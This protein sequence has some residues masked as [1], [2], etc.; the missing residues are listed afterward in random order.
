M[1]DLGTVKNINLDSNQ[2]IKKDPN[3]SFECK[4]DKSPEEIANKSIFKKIKRKIKK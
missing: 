2:K 1:K 3:K 4:G